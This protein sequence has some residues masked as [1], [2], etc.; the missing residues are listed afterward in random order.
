[1]V[2]SCLHCPTSLDY[3]ATPSLLIELINRRC[4]FFCDKLLIS[5]LQF[6]TLKY[7]L[8][9]QKCPT[10]SP[11]DQSLSFFLQTQY[12][13]CPLTLAQHCA[14][15]CSRSA[16]DTSPPSTALIAHSHLLKYPPQIFLFYVMNLLHHVRISK[17]KGLSDLQDQS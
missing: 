2:T 10:C 9:R 13:A 7:F 14:P 11:S 17:A 15:K 8:C 3:A 6:I 5:F 1:M 4:I 16:P 12:K